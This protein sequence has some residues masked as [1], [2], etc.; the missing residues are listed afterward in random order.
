MHNCSDIPFFAGDS[1][2]ETCQDI[3]IVESIEIVDGEEVTIFTETVVPIPIDTVI[4]SSVRDALGSLRTLT[5][6]IAI[7]R[8]SYTLTTN[9]TSA[10]AAGIAWRD[11]KYTNGSIVEHTT[12]DSFLIKKA[13]TP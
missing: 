2:L 5:V 13:I 12:Q 8:L 9:S 4:A 1:Y 6:T 11:I 3:E 7:D 10:W